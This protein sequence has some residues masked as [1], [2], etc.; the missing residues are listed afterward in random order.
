[1]KPHSKVELEN[2]SKQSFFLTNK[3]SNKIKIITKDT[4]NKYNIS[5]FWGNLED[6]LAFMLLL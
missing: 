2:R 4:P 3:N 5:K 1:M 6:S